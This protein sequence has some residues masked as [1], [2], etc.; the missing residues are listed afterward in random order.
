QPSPLIVL[1]S[2]Q[3]SPARTFRMP[4]PHLESVQ[5]ALHVIVGDPPASHCSPAA[6]S[7]RPLPQI[8]VL[9]QSALQPSPETVLPSSHTSPTVMSTRPLPQAS[10]L[11]QSALQ[12][13]P[14]NWLPS[15]HI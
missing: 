11:R 4:S 13:S 1:P 6:T 8:S 14:E 9:R 15:S 2:S 7:T 12:P 5:L 10:L 3:T